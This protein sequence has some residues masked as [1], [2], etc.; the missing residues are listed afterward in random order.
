MGL[1]FLCRFY[2]GHALH[3]PAPL[4]LVSAGVRLRRVHD[5]GRVHY[6]HVLRDVSVVAFGGFGV[7]LRDLVLVAFLELVHAE[8]EI[9]KRAIASSYCAS[10]HRWKGSSLIC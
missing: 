3:E 7:V 8:V 9:S 6:L 5:H 1:S 10:F 4:L 2:S